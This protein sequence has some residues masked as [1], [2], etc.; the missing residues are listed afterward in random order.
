MP[1]PSEP[2]ATQPLPPP[3]TTPRPRQQSLFE[4]VSPVY[5]DIDIENQNVVY[6]QTNFKPDVKQFQPYQELY[7]AAKKQPE[8][9]DDLPK[10]DVYIHTN[11][12]PDVKE[13]QP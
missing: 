4:A 13:F 1:G 3:P 5:E 10:N 2:V 7:E 9:H 6:D 8:G 12:K 11:F